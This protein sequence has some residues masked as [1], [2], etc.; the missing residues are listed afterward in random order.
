M[1][2][3]EIE[4]IEDD[5]LPFGYF[6]DGSDDIED[7]QE[8]MYWGSEKENWIITSKNNINLPWINTKK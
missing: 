5:M 2:Q 6:N 4:K 8:D 1:Y 7:K 3:N